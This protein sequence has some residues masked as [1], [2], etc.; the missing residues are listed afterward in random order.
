VFMDINHELINLIWY[1]V[2]FGFSLFAG[3]LIW[4]THKYL[5]YKFHKDQ[6]TG[7]R[8]SYTGLVERGLYTGALLADYPAFVGIWL[9]LKSV[10]HWERFK[11]DAKLGN[12][13]AT[14]KF[15]GY[16][17]DTGLSIAYGFAGNFITRNL[18]CSQC[19]PAIALAVGLV[20]VHL[21]LNIFIKSKAMKEERNV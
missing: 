1:A 11:A 15:N 5:Y 18:I 14:A 16:F 8:S 6:S 10:S 7:W 19:E 4:Y 9:T 20:V 12:G 17:V 3:L 13:E 2:G 21:I